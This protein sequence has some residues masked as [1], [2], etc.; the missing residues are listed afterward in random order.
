MAVVMGDGPDSVGPPTYGFSGVCLKSLDAGTCLIL[1]VILFTPAHHPCLAFT[2]I[3]SLSPSAMAPG[4]RRWKS[5]RK[6][7]IGFS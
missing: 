6:L 5:V 4:I 3:L 1:T 7:T 2:P